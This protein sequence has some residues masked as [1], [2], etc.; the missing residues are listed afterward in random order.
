PSQAGGGAGGRNRSGPVGLAA[1]GMPR[2][3]ATPSRQRPRTRPYLV[4]TVASMGRTLPHQVI[5]VTCDG[6]GHP[7]NRTARASTEN[8]AHTTFPARPGAVQPHP[9]LSEAT[10]CRPRPLS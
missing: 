4:V 8:V 9:L 7:D 10:T 1:Y 3:L 2:N 6:N 5:S